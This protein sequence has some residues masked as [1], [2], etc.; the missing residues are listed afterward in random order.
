MPRLCY[1]EAKILPVAEALAA[2]EEPMR[3]LRMLL[4]VIALFLATPAVT[5]SPDAWFE[6]DAIKKYLEE[7][8]SVALSFPPPIIVPP[9]TNPPPPQTALVFLADREDAPVLVV[10]V[11]PIP[12][13]YLLHSIIISHAPEPGEP[14][15]HPHPCTPWPTCATALVEHI[16]ESLSN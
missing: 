11:I 1:H 2:W 8:H 14:Y 10:G 16:W 9:P 4:G 15:P 5:E 12:D 6:L 3:T 7:N 13:G